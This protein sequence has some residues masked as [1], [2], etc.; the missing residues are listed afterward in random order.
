MGMISG[1]L[2]MSRRSRRTNLLRAGQLIDEIHRSIPF[3]AAPHRP[4]PVRALGI[5]GKHQNR[6]LGMLLHNLLEYLQAFE[7]IFP[8]LA[9]ANVQQDSFREFLFDGIKGRQPRT[10]HL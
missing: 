3:E 10:P 4:L 6:Q 1:V 2:P 8:V 9:Q 5:L 7:L